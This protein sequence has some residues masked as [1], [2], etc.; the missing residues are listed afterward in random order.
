MP[1]V[2]KE[3]LIWARDTAGLSLSEAAH[4]L[5]LSSTK[6][7]SAEER[8][9]AIE[10]GSVSPTRQLLQKMSHRYRRPLLVFYLDEPPRRGDRGHDFRAVSG[11]QQRELEPNLDALIRDIRARQ[12]LVSSILQEEGAE[13]LPYVGSARSSQDPSSI[14][15]EVQKSLGFRLDEFRSQRSVDKAFAYVR[16]LIEADGIFVILA[17][18]LGSHHSNIPPDV[19]RGYAL[20]D[21][22]APFIVVNDQDAHS[23][24]AFTA[25]HE[26]CHIWLGTTGVSGSA[27]Q[28]DIEQLCNEVAG[29]LL[30]PSMELASLADIGSVT[31][32]VAVERI[33]LFAKE[34]NL[35]RSMV[36]YRLLLNRLVDDGLWQRFAGHFR[37]EWLDSKARSKGR[38]EESDGPNYYVVRKH[39][40][41]EALLNLIQRSLS[42][43]AI[44]RTKAGRVLGVKPRNVDPLIRR[45]FSSEA[46]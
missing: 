33:T 8:L 30:L 16:S 34:R 36:A 10:A 22:I 14:A 21:P 37:Q 41:G 39:R 13:Q 18:N 46:Q 1:A 2:N 12:N 11:A 15:I 20:A 27:M 9:G 5:G 24:W 38:S 35:S 42:E 40:L 17:G 45:A 23:A 32:P 7:Q 25:L 3:I 6:E 28:S 44:T 4:G 43:G 19:F 31:F 29:R 26:L